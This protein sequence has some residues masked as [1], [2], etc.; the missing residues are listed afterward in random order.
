MS[1]WHVQGV[2]E[3]RLIQLQS[4]PAIV[5]KIWIEDGVMTLLLEELLEYG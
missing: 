1:Y 2:A 5:S 3:H 4:D